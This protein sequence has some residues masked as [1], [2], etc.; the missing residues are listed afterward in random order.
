MPVP[1][2]PVQPPAQSAG[3]DGTPPQE[4]WAAILENARAKTRAEVAAEFSHKYGKYDQF[5]QDPW[6][7]M[8]A[9]LG[10][11]GQ[12]SVYGPMVKQWAG[13]YLDSQQGPKSLGEEPKADIPVV[14][15]RGTI[16]SY[17][18]S[19]KQLK[20][21]HQWNQAQTQQQL[22]QRFA[23]LEQLQKQT[24]QREAHQQRVQEANHRAGQT[25]SELRQS[26]YFKAHEHDIREALEQHEEWGDNVH[27]AFN[28][29]L[30]TKILPTLSQAE[31]RSV[32]TSLEQQAGATTVAPGGTTS[33]TPQFKTFRDAAEYYASHPAEAAAKAQR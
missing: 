32:I 22:D 27:A 26:P 7:V 6:K 11:A 29:V 19:D 24:I 20:Q 3:S 16:T 33:G 4:R 18:Y 12:H 1:A 21:W 17:T 14:D 28:H 2:T 9:W 23:P 13:Q 10:E 25:L 30:V 31:Q 15:D 8:Q 5:E